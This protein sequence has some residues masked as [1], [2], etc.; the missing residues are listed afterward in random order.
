MTVD[1]VGEAPLRRLVGDDVRTDQAFE[2]ERAPP[3]G[4]LEDTESVEEFL[5]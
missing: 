2:E 4:C 5:G 1:R 3:V